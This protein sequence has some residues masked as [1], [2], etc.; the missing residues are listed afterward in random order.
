MPLKEKQAFL[1]LANQH[2][3]NKRKA[4]FK[5]AEAS[6]QETAKNMPKNRKNKPTAVETFFKL[7]KHRK[8][9]DTAVTQIGR[10]KKWANK[11]KMVNPLK[12]PKVKKSLK[13]RRTTA[14]VSDFVMRQNGAKGRLAPQRKKNM[15]SEVQKLEKMSPNPSKTCSKDPQTQTNKKN[16]QEVSKKLRTHLMKKVKG[17][18]RKVHIDNETVRTHLLRYINHEKFMNSLTHKRLYCYKMSRGPVMSPLARNELIYVAPAKGA[19]FGDRYAVVERKNSHQHTST[20][21]V[22]EDLISILVGVT[23]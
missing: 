10:T 19:F 11:K 23:I 5:T 17:I 22:M 14:N 21:N 20:S 15:K 9:A 4:I 3:A 13:G 12:F 2:W 16:T 1:K 7:L 8:T 6:P 18:P